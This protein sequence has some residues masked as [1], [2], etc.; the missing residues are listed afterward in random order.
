MLHPLHQS[1]RGVN[2]KN[3][4]AAYVKEKGSW[5]VKPIASSRG[6]GIYLINNVSSEPPMSPDV[7]FFPCFTGLNQ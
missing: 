3:I 2:L 7:A 4:S 6:R 1:N 5:I